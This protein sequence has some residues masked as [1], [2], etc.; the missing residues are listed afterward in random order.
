MRDKVKRIMALLLSVVLL[1][2]FMQT[3]VFA[4]EENEDVLELK[5]K[6]IVLNKESDIMP[7]TF[8]SDASIAVT[9]TE[10]GMDIYIVTFVDGEASYVGVKDIIVWHKGWFGIW[11]EVATS[12]GARVDGHSGMGCSIIYSNA[13]VG[14]TYK[15]EC[16]HYAEVDGEYKELPNETAEFK[17]WDN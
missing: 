3:E 1:S 11:K 4:A 10:E 2:S 14:D 5:A 12:T 17:F 16:V 15:I 13:V 7:L 8:F 9:H 6:A